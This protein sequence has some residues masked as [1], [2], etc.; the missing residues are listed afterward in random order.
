VIATASPFN[1]DL[2][3]SLGASVVFD[4]KDPEVVSKIKAETGGALELA[5]DCVSIQNTAKLIGES[6]SDK[7]GR[8][9][10]ILPIK[11]DKE[12]GLRPEVGYIFSTA[13]LLFGKVRVLLFPSTP[14]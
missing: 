4:Y 9:A 2:V 12:G 1:H 6:L 3:K 14:V 7:G 5:V 8:V 11:T 10:V 13:Y